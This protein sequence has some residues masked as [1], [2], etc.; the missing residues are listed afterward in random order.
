MTNYRCGDRFA[1]REGKVQT[2]QNN[3]TA[4]TSRMD[5]LE[6]VQQSFAP[7]DIVAEVRGKQLSFL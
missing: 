7:P 5:S 4:L 1:E 3:A 2:H 6:S